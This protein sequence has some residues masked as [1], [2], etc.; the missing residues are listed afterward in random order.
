MEARLQA[1]I[2]ATDADRSRIQKELE[3][4]TAALDATRA[5][6]ADPAFVERAPAHVVE[7]ARSREAELAERVA[8]L[9]ASL[10][11]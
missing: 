5:R 10:R 6:L 9:S 11:Q 4:A 8:R 7:G 3:D 2:E 1:E